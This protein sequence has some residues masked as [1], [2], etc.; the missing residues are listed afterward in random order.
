MCNPYFKIIILLLLSLTTYS[1]KAGNVDLEL[2]IDIDLS[3]DVEFKQIGKFSFT[4]T[5]HGPDD[6]GAD[7]TGDFPVSMQTSPIKLNPSGFVDVSF[8]K[9][10]TIAQECFFVTVVAEPPPGGTV[11]YGYKFGLPVIPANSSITCY[12][13]YHVGFEFGTKTIKWTAR[14]FSDNDINM[15]NEVV[16]MVFGISSVAIPSSNFY[17]LMLLIILIL[18]F[19]SRFYIKA[20]MKS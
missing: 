18:L 20:H 11:S 17:T 3:A 2:Q 13:L 15:G 1:A 12:G 9:D 5:N 10:F 14:S 16:E 7:T 19:R 8:N 4:V 6:A